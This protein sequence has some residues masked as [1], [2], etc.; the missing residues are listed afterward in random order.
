MKVGNL[1]TADLGTLDQVR[2]LGISQG[3]IVEK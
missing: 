1:H 3:L 2:K